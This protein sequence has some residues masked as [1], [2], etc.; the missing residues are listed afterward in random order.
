M[1][2]TRF[3]PLAAELEGVVAIA[4]QHVPPVQARQRGVGADVREEHR[5]HDSRRAAQGRQFRRRQFALRIRAVQGLE[6]LA[7]GHSRLAPTARI[8]MPFGGGPGQAVEK[9]PGENVDQRGGPAQRLLAVHLFGWDRAFEQQPLEAA[10]LG[11]HL[12]QRQLG[13]LGRAAHAARDQIDLLRLLLERRVQLATQ[14]RQILF[15]DALVSADA[16]REVRQHGV[17]LAQHLAQFAAFLDGSVDAPAL[18]TVEMSQHLL[19]PAPLACECFDGF[20]TP[21]RLPR[22]GSLGQRLVG[23]DVERAAQQ[24]QPAFVGVRHQV[25]FDLAIHRKVGVDFVERD[26]V[27][28]QREFVPVAQQ[29]NLRILRRI[30]LHQ[31]QLHHRLVR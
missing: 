6:N 25:L 7:D 2:W 1:L 8:V 29:A 5:A 3:T 17:A 24:F 13:L 27:A 23:L 22:I 26:A 15:R 18:A 19:V 16:P 20:A 31:Q 9:A 11:L 14:D 28:Q 10:A 21:R 12:V 30:G 4:G